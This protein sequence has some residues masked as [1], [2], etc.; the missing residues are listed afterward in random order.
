MDKSGL[1]TGIIAGFYEVNMN[2]KNII[3]ILERK[4]SIPNDDES[5]E[6]I[7]KAYDDA[8]HI[9]TSYLRI[10]GLIDLDLSQLYDDECNEKL[11]QIKR[12]VD[13]TI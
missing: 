13:N 11:S 12:I 7:E 10:C 2:I 5:W 8:I 9:L 1:E 3:K 6:D 4:S